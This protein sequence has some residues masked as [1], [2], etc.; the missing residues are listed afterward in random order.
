[1]NQVRV[2]AADQPFRRLLVPAAALSLSA[3][4]LVGTGAV[5]AQESIDGTWT[6][7]T[8]I[9]SVD[10]GSGT[11]VGF[12][13]SEVLDP[14]G[15][16]LVVGRTPA[17]SGQ[18]EAAGTVIEHI[19][20]EADLTPLRTDNDFRNGAIQRTL[21]TGDFPAASFVS[22]EPVDLGQLPTEGEVFE[23]TVP[24]TLTIKDV[25]QD[26]SVDLQ[27]GRA[28]DTVVVVGTW[29]IEFGDFGVTMPSAPIVVS[30]EDNGS[31]EWQIFFTRDAAE[32]DAASAEPDAAADAAATGDASEG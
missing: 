16:N 30:V 23:V 17:V 27:A 32:A 28:G 8:S 21:Q 26:I 31:L 13:V 4:F 29:P 22:T 15:E 12:R 6:V 18:L 11:F 9:G 10:D 2:R 1:V 19:A 20:I 5:R 25:S 3:A 7:D 24:G 14:G